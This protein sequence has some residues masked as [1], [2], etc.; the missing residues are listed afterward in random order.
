MV[1]PEERVDLGWRLPPVGPPVQE[2]GRRE[3]CAQAGGVVLLD[4]PIRWVVERRAL[5]LLRAVG[6][7]VDAHVANTHHRREHGLVDGPGEG[8]RDGH[9]QDEEPRLEARTSKVSAPSTYHRMNPV[10]P[11]S[12]SKRS[13]ELDDLL[14]AEGTVCALDASEL[15]RR[16]A[17][18][19]EA[20]IGK[21]APSESKCPPPYHKMSSSEPGPKDRL[22][23]HD[24]DAEG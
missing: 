6:Q 12:Y 24:A 19:E 15:P 22:R 14:A 17:V 10:G 2:A 3:Q 20:R 21:Y 23:Y 4:P 5:C 16:W 1:H 18:C 7:L 9:A 13:K 8:A 11:G